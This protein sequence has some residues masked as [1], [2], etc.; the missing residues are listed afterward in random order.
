MGNHCHTECAA[1]VA[2]GVEEHVVFPSVVVDEGL[3][4]LGVL[5]LVD[6]DGKEFYAGLVLPVFIDFGNV[7]E[8]AV[9]RFAPAGE[10]A[11]DKGLAVVVE[12]GG[13]NG[14]SVDGAEVD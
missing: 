9:A 10:E 14:L 5:C 11:D 12:G 7:R 8:F 2:V 6:A 1:E 4:L 3:H 13:I